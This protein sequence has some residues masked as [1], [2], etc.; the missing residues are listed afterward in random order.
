M[1]RSAQKKLFFLRFAA[2]KNKNHLF[3]R[4]FSPR[5]FAEKLR[6]I[7]RWVGKDLRF[8]HADSEDSDQMKNLNECPAWYESSLDG[9]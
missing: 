8:L 7:S 5:N 2:E 1:Y 4:G 3:R 6:E 9:S